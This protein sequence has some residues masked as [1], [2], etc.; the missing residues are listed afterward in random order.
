MEDMEHH[1]RDLMFN[2]VIECDE[3]HKELPNSMEIR[4][5]NQKTKSRKTEESQLMSDMRKS[6]KM[7]NEGGR[8]VVLES[9][10]VRLEDLDLDKLENEKLEHDNEISR[11]QDAINNITGNM[12]MVELE[13]VDK[14]FE[15]RPTISDQ[16]ETEQVINNMQFEIEKNRKQIQILKLKQKFKHQI[17]AYKQMLDKRDNYQLANLDAPYVQPAYFGDD[18]I[19]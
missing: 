1:L 5:T 13:D 15:M 18:L 2:D 3:E 6:M 10:V 16:M 12:T 17:K 14:N 4:K 7:I 19:F 9:Q 8:S 11:L